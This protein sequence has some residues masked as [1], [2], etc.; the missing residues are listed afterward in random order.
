MFGLMLVSTHRAKLD[1]MA[2][3]EAIHQR[4]INDTLA[5][6]RTQL[7]SADSRGQKMADELAETKQALATC[8]NHAETLTAQ[9][10]ANEPFVAAGKAAK[11]R[12]TAM[13]S[14]PKKAAAG[15]AAK[16]PATAKV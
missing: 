5:N 3:K 11:A 4:N 2:K 9:I 14:T 15:G 10:T 6:L 12:E 13:K 1:E 16:R 8:R 7:A